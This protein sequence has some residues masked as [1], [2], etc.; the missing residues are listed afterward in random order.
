MSEKTV[1][2]TK[3]RYQADVKVYF[4]RYPSQAKWRNI[5]KKKYFEK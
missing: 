1:F 4:V 2:F 3:Y 5:E